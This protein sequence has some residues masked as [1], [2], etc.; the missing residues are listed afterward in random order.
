MAKANHRRAVRVPEKAE[1]AHGIQL[2]QSL[3]ATVYKLGGARRRGDYQGTMQT[4]GLPD[5]F[6]FLPVRGSTRR[7]AFWWECKAAGGRVRPE[8]RV[9]LELCADADLVHILGT[10]DDLIAWLAARDY[11]RTDQFPH[12]RQPRSEP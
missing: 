6:G 10:F 1:Q 7:I 9:F 11:V 5:V 4:E 8:Q 2:L 3:G 12:Y